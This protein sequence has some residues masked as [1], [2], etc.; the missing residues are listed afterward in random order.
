LHITV[1]VDGDT[2]KFVI[3]VVTVCG[4]AELSMACTVN[5]LLPAAVGVP[6]TIPVLESKV[7]PL[8]KAPLLIKYVYGPV[9]PA[10]VQAAL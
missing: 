4:V 2:A 7:K 9:P 6:A 10:A 8:G 1:K 5:E 3:D